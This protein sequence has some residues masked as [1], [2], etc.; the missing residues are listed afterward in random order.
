MN[1][2]KLGLI[3]NADNNN[4]F[5]FVGGRTPIA[6]YLNN[7]LFE[8]YFAAYDAQMRGRIFK[9]I[10]DL[11]NPTEILYLHKEPLVDFGSVGYYD[12]NGIIPSCILQMDNKL[13]LYTIGFSLKNKIIFDAATSLAISSDNGNSFEKLKGTILDRGIDDPCFAV[14]P[15]VLFDNGLFRMWYVSCDKWEVNSDGS[16]KHFYNI[17]YKESED[18][19]V[20]SVR[21][22]VCIDYKNDFEY[23]ISRPSVIKDGDND[24]KMW[25]SYRAQEFVD[26]YRIG[27]AESVDGLNW[28]R[29]DEQMEGFD[30]SASGWDSEMICYPSVF[31]HNGSR[32]MLYNGNHYGRSG[33]GIAIL[34]K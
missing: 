20:W 27:Y 19:I 30:V 7:D 16:Y 29:K 34:E 17:K 25:Y 6:R 23:A 1:W 22:V 8:I 13:F 4:E 26:S 32:Y 28:I 24:Y 18:G 10:V 11:K 12:D 3:F 31:D 14:S 33:F 9:L 21:S 5:M 2:K 15:S